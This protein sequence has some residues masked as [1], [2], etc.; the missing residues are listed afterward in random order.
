MPTE[1]EIK[2]VRLDEFL[3]WLARGWTFPHGIAQPITAGPHA[4]WSCIME[5]ETP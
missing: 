4:Y 3:I 5:R 2:Y 1:V